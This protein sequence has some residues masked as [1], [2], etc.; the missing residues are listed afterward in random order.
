MEY[1]LNDIVYYWGFVYETGELK[2]ETCKVNQYDYLDGAQWNVIDEYILTTTYE[3]TKWGFIKTK[4]RRRFRM[5]GHLISH[6]IILAK[7]TFL[8]H[9]LNAFSY[10]SSLR[11][12]E[13]QRMI[14]VAEK[15]Y[16][17]YIKEFPELILKA[18]KPQQVDSFTFRY[19]DN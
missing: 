9:F 15:E 12:D 10:P 18:G 7:I 14:S 2:Y 11:S 6:D 16:Q 1:K 5:P 8:F 4:D 13:R 17:H 3:S 19:F